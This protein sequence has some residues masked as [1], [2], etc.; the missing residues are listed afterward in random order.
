MRGWELN[1]L[2]PYKSN[3]YTFQSYYLHFHL[4][5][6]LFLISG[7]CA[8]VLHYQ[9]TVACLQYALHIQFAKHHCLSE[10]ETMDKVHTLSNPQV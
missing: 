10:Y 9:F 6:Q 1:K 4:S 5:L 8:T 7:D 3:Y 2:L